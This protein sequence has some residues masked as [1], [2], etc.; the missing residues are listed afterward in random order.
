MPAQRP[1]LECGGHPVPGETVVGG[2]VCQGCWQLLLRTATSRVCDRVMERIDRRYRIDPVT[3]SRVVATALPDRTD[4]L[5]VWFELDAR[6]LVPCRASGK[7]SPQLLAIAAE[8]RRNGML[9]IHVGQRRNPGA[10]GGHGVCGQ[11]GKDGN[12]AGRIAGISHCASCWRKH[13]S[14]VKPCV[15]CGATDYLNRRRL[16]R[17][18]HRRDEVNALFTPDRTAN[19]P[20]LKTARDALLDAEAGYL[21]SIMRAGTA[22]K[23][24]CQLL[25][26]ET[27]IT[28]E[29][30]DA[31]GQPGTSMLRSFL[32]ATGV[33]PERN[34]RLHAFEQWILRTAQTVADDADRRS[35]VSFARWRHL[36]VARQRARTEAQFAG[37][38]RE[39]AQ[40]RQ[41]LAMLHTRGLTILS[42]NQPTLD[43]WLAD[44]PTERLRVKAFLRWCRASGVQT[45]LNISGS[46]AAPLP[47][48]F[49]IPE[50]ERAMLLRKILDPQAEIEPALRLAAALVLIY[51]FRSH[52]IAGLSLTDISLGA[53]VVSIR[54]GAEPL[55]LPEELGTYARQAVDR[56]GI[57]RF[58]GSTQDHAWLFP[59]PFHGRAIGPLTLSRRLAALGVRADAARTTALG[60]L[61]Q[62]LPPPILARLTGLAPSTTISWRAAVS[63]SY[64]ANL[65]TLPG[66]TD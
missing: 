18:C 8:L 45:A 59:S 40:V 26:S 43:A 14:V 28:H 17:G 20:A 31:A 57:T 50:Q 48:V 49:L 23:I 66:S 37:Q 51:G 39:L 6:G 7:R 2:A 19:L 53:E 1:C 11:C 62:Q 33:L 41:L 29:A 58:G 25:T 15:R 24:L 64:A 38:R 27:D 5:R 34:E 4:R 54:F 32:T 9:G 30:L 13:E 21:D 42:A 35:F 55:H 22:W 65:P 47:A 60:N 56:R 12:V 36:R 16:C 10:V 44:G 3:V 52:K 46:V 61:S 63:A